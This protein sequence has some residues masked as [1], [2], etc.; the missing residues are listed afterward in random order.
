[1][2]RTF[3]VP[4][5]KLKSRLSKF[6]YQ[7]LKLVSKTKLGQSLLTLSTLF[8]VNQSRQTII[9]GH[10]ITYSFVSDTWLPRRFLD[11][12]TL[13]PDTLSWIDEMIEGSTFWDIGANVG[14]YSIYA[15][16]S[17]GCA[18]FAFEP[19][20]FNLEFLAR[21]IWL[22]NLEDKITVIPIALSQYA[23]QAPFKMR[24][25]E[26]AG[27][28]SS[29]GETDNDVSDSESFKYVTIGLPAD[30]VR[31]NFK[32]PFPESIKLDVDGIEALIL[33]GATEVLTKTKS[34]LV[35]VQHSEAEREAIYSCL[36]KSGLSKRQVARHNEIW[37]RD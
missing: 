33:A 19:S 25:I 18:V 5:T 34:V 14:G 28:G 16:K 30:Q 31:E 27:S 8:T 32:I 7:I 10:S 15:A 24:R 36:S 23:S 17:K 37:T 9:R 35:E 11:V 13:E 3:E 12:E 22:N 1:M 4:P 26:W 2:A 20:P 29:F 21:N 6:S